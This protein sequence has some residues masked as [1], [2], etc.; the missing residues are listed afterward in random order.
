MRSA[1]DISQHTVL[2]IGPGTG[3]LTR[4]ILYYGTPQLIVIEKDPRCLPILHQLSEFSPHMTIIEG[5][6]MR[7]D[8]TELGVK[9]P[10]KVIAN[11]PYNIGTE[12]LFGWLE[13]ID[14]FSSFTI[15]LQKEV[16][17]RIVATP[18]S[19]SFG[20]L[21]IL[22]QLLCETHIALTLPPEAFIPPPKVE[23]SVVH[24]VKRTTPK[25]DVNIID[26]KHVCKAIFGQRRKMIRA[27]LKQITDDP[28]SLC[29]RADV[30]ETSR[31]ESLSIE[32]LCN[33]ANIYRA[34]H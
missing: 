16:A 17:Q 30:D 2:E 23:S 11:L 27:S 8:F 32:Q 29:K 14:H 28:L 33:L 26:L 21:S 18:N 19:K 31:P 22:S 9:S 12:L 13:N 24:M 6:A 20:Y 5:D 25:C 10:I 7:I 15:M 34:S 3:V 1:G 4:S